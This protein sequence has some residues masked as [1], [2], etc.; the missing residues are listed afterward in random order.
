ME[1]FHNGRRLL[2]FDA[3]TDDD[4]SPL[5]RD[6]VEWKPFL[7]W[8]SRVEDGFNISRI[9][10][11]DVFRTPRGRVLFLSAKVF[12][13]NPE[14]A[15]DHIT[16][17][18]LREDVVGALVVVKRQVRDGNEWIAVVEQERIASGEVSH[19]EIVAGIRDGELPQTCALREIEEELGLLKL[20]ITLDPDRLFP[21]APLPDGTNRPIAVS[22]GSST[23]RIS[24]FAYQMIL[25]DEAI[26]RL[27]GHV[28]GLES[29][30]E[31][32]TVRLVH[33]NKIPEIGDLKTIA[34]LHLYMVA[35]LYI[36]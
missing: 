32:T 17:M 3:N 20:G 5:L 12:W 27:D 7:D 9:L 13:R 18:S 15:I 31:R 4:T 35:Q 25:P 36:G 23:E 30:G 6:V 26:K 33:V 19:H 8:L 1:F 10:F 14:H 34:A 16:Y 29:E 24:L 21:L 11:T 22:S 2:L 28:A